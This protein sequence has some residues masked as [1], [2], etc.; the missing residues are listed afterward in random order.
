MQFRYVCENIGKEYVMTDGED[1]LSSEEE[2]ILETFQK[3]LPKIMPEGSYKVVFVDQFEG[4]CAD[5]YSDWGVYATL[6]EAIKVARR[7]TED[8]IEHCKSFE[9]WYGMGDGGL[10][11]D[12]K[13]T[14]VWNGIQEYKK[15]NEQQQMKK[16]ES[17]RRII[18]AI[19]FATEA[20][21]QQVRKG[22]K[23]PYVT[24]PTGAGMILARFGCSTD[25]IVAGILHDCIEDPE[26]PFEEIQKRFGSAVAEIVRDCSEPDKKASWLDRKKHT[27]ERLKTV[28]DDACI[29]SC[30]D[31]LHNLLSMIKDYE[32]LGEQLWAKFNASKKDQVWYYSWLGSSFQRRADQRPI[33]RDYQD[34]LAVFKKLVEV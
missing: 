14:L 16:V 17:Y 13:G 7:I 25:Q 19:E 15:M 28:S 23:I 24:H 9:A 34:C 26:V 2:M 22:T 30:A 27:I 5:G 10:V 33:Y 12:K 4:H 1:K 8:G 32:V 29:V 20:H 6:E 11:Y 18:D 21:G 3:D 31:K